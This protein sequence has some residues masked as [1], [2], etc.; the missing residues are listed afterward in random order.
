MLTTVFLWCIVKGKK[1]KAAAPTGIAAANVEIEGTDV[2]AQTM[3]CMFDL[4]TE[5]ATRLDF[6]KFDHAKVATLMQLEV[7]LLDEV[8]ML[9]VDCFSSLSEILSIVDHNKRPNA[10]GADTFGNVHMM[11]FGDFKQLPPATSKAP[12]I[13]FP[14]VISGFDFRVLRQVIIIFD[15]MLLE[16]NPSQFSNEIVDQ[17]R[18][19]VAGDASR[20]HELENFH[21][22]LSD[23]SWGR[24]TQR[25]R[26][27]IIEAYVRGADCGNA[28]RAELEGSTSVF[29][30]R[31]FRES[32]LLLVLA[33]SFC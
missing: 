15:P 7:L 19:V 20:A 4:D 6:S 25:V 31:R 2:A 32:C 18:R 23:I 14:D 33:P 17:N 24:A 10:Q 30:K 29:T 16:T 21:E 3:H 9:D 12:F 26:D 28:E 13:V 1:C 8:S 11:L 27:F 5:F 22:V